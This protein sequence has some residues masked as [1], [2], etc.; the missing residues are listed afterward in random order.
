MQPDPRLEGASLASPAEVE[1]LQQAC[2]ALRSVFRRRE[3]AES[4]VR[5]VRSILGWED[6]SVLLL[7]PDSAGRLHLARREGRF[8]RGARASSIGERVAF[9]TQVALHVP[10]REPRGRELAML[11][12][13]F[14]GR[15]IGILEIE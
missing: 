1:V 13:V 8:S 7:L 11:P 4:T 9:E 6:S 2:L 15:S 14:G 12:L 5:W 10:L 3:A